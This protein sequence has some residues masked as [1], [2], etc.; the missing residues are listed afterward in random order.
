[1]ETFMDEEAFLERI[2]GSKII[3]CEMYKGIFKDFYHALHSQPDELDLAFYNT[4]CIPVKGTILELA[5]GD[6]RISIPLIRKG[7]SFIGIQW[8]LECKS[9]I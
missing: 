7:C 9:G 2:H 1:M 3:N 4:E 6:G 5:C 8:T